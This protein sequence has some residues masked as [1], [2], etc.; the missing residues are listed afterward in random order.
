[1]MSIF[2]NITDTAINDL[3]GGL[4]PQ[5]YRVLSECKCSERKPITE[6]NRT[7]NGKEDS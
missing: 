5:C 3:L 4:C 6:V 2:R 7:G 1:M